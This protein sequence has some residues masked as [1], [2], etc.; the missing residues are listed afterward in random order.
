MPQTT[1]VTIMFTDVVG[2]T[3]L[4][5][6]LGDEVAGSVLR[7]HFAVL[8]R[9]ASEHGGREVKNLGDGLMIVFS[10][11]AAAAACAQRMQRAVVRHNATG[12][13]SALSLRIG[14]HCG[15]VQYE[16]GDYFGKQVVIAKRLC[17]SCIG[18]QVLVSAAVR[19]NLADDVR[20]A[21]HGAITLRGLTEPVTAAELQWQ[22]DADVISE[23]LAARLTRFPLTLI[24][25]AATPPR[26]CVAVPA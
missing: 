23:R 14:I 21:D 3:E 25:S 4:Y 7:R 19:A 8:R 9:C 5:E 16:N 2:S 17:D 10:R 15:V 6:R 24:G 12:L 20:C 11:A 1:E 22:V 18:G 26:Q 13:E